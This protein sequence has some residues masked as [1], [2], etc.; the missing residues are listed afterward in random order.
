[1]IKV[2]IKGTISNKKFG[3]KCNMTK[4]KEKND[5]KLVVFF[6]SHTWT[7]EMHYMYEI[8]K[9]L[10][11]DFLW[12][13][14]GKSSK[15]EI[16]ALL[17]KQKV[18]DFRNIHLIAQNVKD[19][20]NTPVMYQMLKLYC[21]KNIWF[22]RLDNDEIISAINLK[23]MQEFI[24]DCNQSISYGIGRIWI[25]KI[26]NQYY[27]SK[28][29][30]TVGQKYDIV[31]RLFKL[32]NVRPVTGMH[33]GGVGPRVKQNYNFGTLIN[34]HTYLNENLESRINKIKTYEEISSG[35][36]LSKLRH[37]LPEIFP[38]NIWEKLDSNQTMLEKD[39][40]SFTKLV[41]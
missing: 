20:I 7:T 12:L 38:S 13:F 26:N 18:E 29:A 10:G 22:L 15:K 8:C 32:K 19:H 3:V 5:R 6:Y 11:V 34:H 27:F 41:Y 30:R 4:G 21:E 28:I 9:N 33:S 17:K 25:N 24:K 2:C 35:A 16:Y 23:Y 40:E 31:Y 36:G 1:M 39:F 14:T 37:Y